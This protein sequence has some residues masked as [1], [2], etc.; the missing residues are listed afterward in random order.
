[1]KLIPIQL[2]NDLQLEVKRQ[3]A[4]FNKNIPRRKGRQYPPGLKGLAR[5]ALQ[6]GISPP[7]LHRLTGMSNASIHRLATATEP[8]A[9][10]APKSPKRLEVVG[11]S[12]ATGEPQGATIRL[13]SGVSIELSDVTAL[14]GLLP[15]LIALEV[16][17]AASC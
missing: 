3:F 4:E 12:L 17:H 8:V 9:L 13:P 5:R 10:A 11:E 1:M 15:S 2:G 6:Q 14:G 16:N 7:E